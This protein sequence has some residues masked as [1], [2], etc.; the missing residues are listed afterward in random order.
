MLNDCF[1][2]PSGL[3]LYPSGP[4]SSSSEPLLELPE[5]LVP[6]LDFFGAGGVAAA[7]E[8]PVT[9]RLPS[10]SRY[11]RKLPD[12]RLALHD[13]P[14]VHLLM[15]AS[16]SSHTNTEPDLICC[17]SFSDSLLWTRGK[18]PNRHASK[19]MIA[20]CGVWTLPWYVSMVG[21]QAGRLKW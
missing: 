1:M 14:S 10:I 7:G 6:L 5:L 16:R 9:P 17:R 21:G 8:N 3:Y 4:S 18:R 19:R 20:S 12:T 13:F 11:V 2:S 15:P